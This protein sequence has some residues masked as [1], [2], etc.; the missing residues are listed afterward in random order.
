MATGSAD[1]KKTNPEK[2]VNK[3]EQ[4]PPAPPTETV[5]KHEAADIEKA[6]SR[7]TF[8]GKGE[9][10]VP[11]SNF[12]GFATAGVEKGKPLKPTEE[13]VQEILHGNWGTEVNVIVQRLHEAG[14]QG[15]LLNEIEKE[16]NR[17]KDSGAPSAF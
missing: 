14:Y 17:R 8:D 12:K 2:I 13:V 10:A 1:P 9:N 11:P 4:D 7:H 15:E 3:P 6:L 16:Y 5:A